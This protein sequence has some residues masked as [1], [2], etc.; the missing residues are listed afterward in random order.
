MSLPVSA[1]ISSDLP[2]TSVASGQEGLDLRRGYL[3]F[4]GTI[5]SP[6]LRAQASPEQKLLCSCSFAYSFSLERLVLTHVPLSPLLLPG[7]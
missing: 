6:R 3:I 7:G 4:P 5:I 2:G 1:R